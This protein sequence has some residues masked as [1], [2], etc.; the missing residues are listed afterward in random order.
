VHNAAAGYWSMAAHCHEPYCALGAGRYTFA[1]GLFTAALQV[2]ADRTDVLYVAY[3]IGAQGE[4]AQIAYSEGILGVALVLTQGAAGTTLNLDVEAEPPAQ[5]DF[6]VAGNAMA[7][8][9]PLLA[10]LE[11]RARASFSLPLGPQSRLRVQ[12]RHGG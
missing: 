10:A 6:A 12:V 3:D 7:D 11:T 1:S 9:L 5:T 4:Q 8:A 2:C